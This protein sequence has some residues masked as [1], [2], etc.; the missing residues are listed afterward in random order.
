MGLDGTKFVKYGYLS[1][2]FPIHVIGS[3][4]QF[5]VVEWPISCERGQRKL[6]I[7]DLC[8]RFGYFPVA[9]AL[10]STKRSSRTH[11]E[12]VLHTRTN[13]G[14][15]GNNCS[16]TRQACRKQS[17]E[18]HV[19]PRVIHFFFFRAFVADEA[20][21]KLPI[22]PSLG[23]STLVSHMPKVFLAAIY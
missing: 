13:L 8:H 21:F 1:H 5:I 7:N 9:I 3:S 22:R 6:S 18:Y 17:A 12:R 20:T 11:R 4:K 23:G 19:L 10:M 15:G 16:D 14:P 2:N